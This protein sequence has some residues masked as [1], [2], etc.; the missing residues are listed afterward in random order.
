[1]TAV[2]PVAQLTEQDLVAMTP[3]QITGAVAAGRCAALLGRPVPVTVAAVGQ[4]DGGQ[5]A[6][7]SPEQV[8]A[9]L[10]AGQLRD[11]LAG[12]TAQ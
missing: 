11:V 5:L 10:D 2:E 4:V 8:T 1:V 7:M 12:G 3:E 6:A 9:A